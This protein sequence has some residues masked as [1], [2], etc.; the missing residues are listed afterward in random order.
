MLLVEPY[1]GGSHRAWAEG[2]QAH[3]RHAVEILGLPARFW[4]WRMHGA[5]VTLAPRVGRPPPAIVLASDMLDL[6]AFLGLA[7]DRLGTAAVALY[8]HENQ[9]A[10]P[11]IEAAPDWSASR[12]RR[13]ARLDAYYPFINFSSAMA[14]D[15]VLW[16]SEH[17]RRTFLEALPAF[18][19]RFPDA[20]PG[21]AVEAI[22]AKSEVLPLGLDLT[23][24]AGV[25]LA[26]SGHGESAAD[27]QAGPARIV[28]NHRWE[29][30]KAPERFFS[31]LETL[32]AQGLDFELIVLGEA[33]GRQPEAFAEARERWA[34]RCLHW[35]YAQDRASYFAWL[36]RGDIVVS[37]ARHEF[38]GAAVCEAIAAGCRPLLPRALS[39]PELI[40]ARWQ[41]ALLYPR[42]E[43]FAARLAQAV[44]LVNT[45]RPNRAEPHVLADLRRHIA[46]FD[47]PAMAPR[48]DACLS[49]LARARGASRVGV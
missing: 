31:A 32:A 28:W 26:D 15:R 14:A 4:K 16:N 2:Y 45:A 40:P 6:A 10:Y 29:S 48:Y 43:D 17:N 42:Q 8:F 21:G 20:R 9:L 49:A 7:R 11:P 19:K 33:F 1:L 12:R 44:G 41:A 22:A 36:R 47:W 30:D 34:D 35:G 13:S 23:E 46:R 27:R 39:Y 38:F 5:A 37:T 18:L 25:E 24:A 3:S